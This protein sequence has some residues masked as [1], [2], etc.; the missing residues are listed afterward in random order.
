VTISTANKA[1]LEA[2]H[3]ARIYFVFLDFSGDPFYACTG[4]KTYSFNSQSWF[5]IG[6]IAG[7][8]EITD[9]ADIAA[10]PLTLSLSGVDSAITTPVLSRTNYKGRQAKIYRGLLDTHEDLVDDPYIIWSGRMDV[11]VMMRSEETYIAQMTCEPL[12]ARLL[13]ANLSR[14]SDQD[15]QLRHPGDK[16]FEFLPQM[17]KKDVTWGGHRIAPA[18]G[19]SGWGFGFGN[20]R[21]FRRMF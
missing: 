20:E 17:E 12:T 9:V 14:Y 2:V 5:G 8:S 16:F 4:T 3:S 10:R 18:S 21:T 11:G 13:R 1:A 6:E 15:H 7:I 19:G